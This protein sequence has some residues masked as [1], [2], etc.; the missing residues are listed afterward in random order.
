MRGDFR[1]ANVTAF[2]LAASLLLLLTLCGVSAS[3]VPS[4]LRASRQDGKASDSLS[5][6]L[7]EWEGESVCTD[8]NRPACRNEHVVYHITK[9]EGGGADEETIRADKVVDGK[10]EYMGS[11]DCKYDAGKSTLTCEFTVNT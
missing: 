5:K 11:L 1:I 8:P 6:V 3:A 4:S 9:R 7:G 2:V 10:P